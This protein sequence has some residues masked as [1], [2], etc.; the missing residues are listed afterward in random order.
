[1]AHVSL[2]LDWRRHSRAAHPVRPQAILKIHQCGMV[3][4]DIK[5][6]NIF[7]SPDGSLKLGDFGVTAQVCGCS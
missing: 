4:L 7:L 5:P 2:G 3:H 1:M 6:D